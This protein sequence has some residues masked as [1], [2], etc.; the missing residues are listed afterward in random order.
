MAHDT[1]NSEFRSHQQSQR[2]SKL[3]NINDKTDNRQKVAKYAIDE[4]LMRYCHHA[5][6]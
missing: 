5:I 3:F 4:F 2:A 1:L 6:C